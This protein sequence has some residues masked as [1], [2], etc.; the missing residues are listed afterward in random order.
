MALFVVA[1]PHELSSA[2][3]LAADRRGIPRRNLFEV[4]VAVRVWGASYEEAL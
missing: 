4:A 3:L 1:F 2:A